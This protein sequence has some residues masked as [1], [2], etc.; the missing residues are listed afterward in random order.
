[1]IYAAGHLQTID[2]FLNFPIM[3]VNRNVLWRNPA[4]VSPEQA[5]RLT[6]YW[7]DETWRTEAYRPSAQKGLFDDPLEKADNAKVAEAFRRRLRD[8]AGFAN[9]PKPMPMRNKLGAVVYYL[10]FASQKAVANQIV[11]DIFQKY[12]GKGEG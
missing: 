1:V 6:A 5:A 8:V 4:A 11:E 2:L 10:Y 7:G 3:D 9:V 12:R